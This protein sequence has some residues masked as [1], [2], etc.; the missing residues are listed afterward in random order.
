MDG[1]MTRRDF[2]GTGLATLVGAALGP[3]ILTAGC[4]T[5]AGDPGPAAGGVPEEATRRRPNILLVLV[6]E[7]RRPGNYPAG[8]GEALGLREIF[9]FAPTL[10]PDN[11]F[12]PLF[13]GMT[14]LRQNAVVL[15]T[16]YIAS[17]ACVPSRA[18][19]L[20]GQYPTVH[21]V[22]STTGFFKSGDDPGFV[23]L[24]PDGIPTA[25]DWFQAAGYETYYFGKWHVSEACDDLGP[26][27]FPFA[28]WDGP[29]PHG[30][31]P[32]NLGVY[33]DPE[34]AN[35][36]INFL[37]SKAGQQPGESPWF[38]VTSYLAP[39]DVSGW[40][41]QWFLP[42]D[43]GVQPF[44]G[45]GVIPPIPTTGAISNAATST[46]QNSDCPPPISGPVA[47][48]PGGYPP[49]A[50]NTP[51]TFAEDL[52]TKPECQFDMSFKIGLC[53][54]SILPAPLRPLAPNP[55]Q[56][57]GAD[58]QAWA[59]A[60]GEWWY[61]LH[62]LFDTQLTRV[63]QTLDA[64]GLRDNTIVIFTC[65]HGDYAGAHGG[66]VQKWHSAYEEATHVPLV[67]SSPLVNPGGTL[68]E[69]NLPTSHIDLLPTLLGL[70]GFNPAQQAELKSRIT[71][72]GVVPDLVGTDISG[73]LTDPTN[74]TPIPGHDG[75]PRPGVLFI[76]E[77]EISQ[78]TSVDP[79]NSGF[80]AFETFLRLVE[81]ARLGPVPAL[82]PGPIRQPNL[83]RT[84][85][86]GDWKYSRYYDPNQVAPDQHE[87][88]H[89]PS[90]PTEAINLVEFR[91]NQIRPGVAVPGV[92]QAELT[93]QLNLMVQQLA[94]QEA[95]LL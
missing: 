2:L 42:G 31:D 66:Q 94:Q 53:Q 90:D 72:Q 36:T 79:N 4:T 29:E 86:S 68:Q 19:L 67:V 9:G 48:N 15:R 34:F 30:S 49:G 41:L 20:T 61:Y 25:G 74:T 92:S 87:F 16:H 5:G 56:L 6:D 82:A 26:W 28:A 22:T 10:S 23:F 64:T 47:L 73:Y 84:L 81:E 52:S 37:N 40:P 13:P 7:F 60:Y 76:T 58:Y 50:F 77:D 59:T 27:G 38:A 43:V 54:R 65:D 80:P 89:L 46:S 44:P 8:T 51:P 21:G 11:Q 83:V 1:N 75:N 55:F 14:R 62:Y 3:A 71:G 35:D 57:Q 39:H 85:A 24:D 93:A 45:P 32:A 18:T 12:V 78:M 17:A 70:A 69:V 33:R 63:L 91:T 95:L 88:Y